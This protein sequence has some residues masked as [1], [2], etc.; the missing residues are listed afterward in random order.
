MKVSLS[1]L[2]DYVDLKMASAD[3]VDALTMVGL[4]VD[5]IWDRYEYLDSVLVGR[6]LEIMPH[7]NADKLRICRVDLSQREMSVVCGAP[8]IRVGMHVAVALVG[9][10][11]PGGS[12]LQ[13]TVI[14]GVVSEGM[15]CSES[16]LALG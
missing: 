13:S 5:A 14:R 1:W 16:E 10:Q 9:T 4:E 6:I 2:Q 15:I 11:F 7:P 3:L 8:N 12:Q